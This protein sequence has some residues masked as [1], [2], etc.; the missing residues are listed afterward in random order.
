MC[1]STT[2]IFFFI[3]TKRFAKVKCNNEFQ[4]F[5]KV[6]F[7]FSLTHHCSICCSSLTP[8][9]LRLGF[10]CLLDV[11]FSFAHLFNLRPSREAIVQFVLAHDSIHLYVRAFIA[12]A[13]TLIV[14]SPRANKLKLNLFTLTTNQTK[15]NGGSFS[16]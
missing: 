14:I 9:R 7:L 3:N 15:R 1:Q 5:V 16:L 13:N 11:R 4:S 12:A 8:C 10:C 2:R 6:D